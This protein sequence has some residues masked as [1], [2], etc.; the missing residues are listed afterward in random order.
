[1]FRN[2]S[3]YFSIPLIAVLAVMGLLLLMQAESTMAAP[4]AVCD[5][6]SGGYPT[7]QSAVDDAE[8]SLINLTD[9][10]YVENVTIGRDLKIQ[11]QDALSTTIDGDGN[12]T[13]VVIEN[14]AA[15]TLTDVTI[16]NGYDTYGGGLRV[17]SSEAHLLRT[18]LTGNE[19]IDGPYNLG[20]GG[21]VYCFE[22]DLE[23]RDSLV[24][25]NTSSGSGGGLYHYSANFA[26]TVLIF[27]STFE[28][29]KA[30][31]AG[32]LDFIEFNNN[33]TLIVSHSSVIRNSAFAGGGI[34]V[35]S[36][37]VVTVTNSTIGENV[38][39]S[40]GGGILN[41]N[42][43]FLESSTVC[44]NEQAG[45]HN[46]M[47]TA[48]MHNSIIADNT[49]STDCFSSSGGFVSQGFN[50][51]SDASCN[52]IQPSDMP[53]TNPMLGSLQFNGGNTMTYAPDLASPALENGDNG[54]CPTTDQ[55]GV[56]RPQDGDDDSTADC[57]IGA[58]ER[59]GPLS[60]VSAVNSSPTIPGHTTIFTGSVA[61]GDNVSY[62]WN[63]GDGSTGT[64]QVVG[65]VYASPG[66]YTAEVVA[67]NLFN[68]LT[69]TT[70]VTVTMEYEYLP[71][72]LKP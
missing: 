43:L 9:N 65:H 67:T 44:E 1:M 45:V 34:E 55:R 69:A 12:G 28:E 2:R 32:G 52:L 56:S 53:N 72:I 22:C 19:T 11:G 18:T 17:D 40:Y 15:V 41:Y 64:G 50:L 33:D 29:N 70:V 3:I 25:S 58:V 48:Y 62:A 13:T 31:I 6:P 14:G 5:V 4:E 59:D 8:C 71:V 35:Y 63:F 51:A 66:L 61:V 7:I 60:G 27:N 49:L 46:A 38:A 47:A 24:Y 39:E 37:A 57:D 20:M 21:G 10:W 16:T 68:S 26:N 23:I 42:T 36:G 30:H 54:S